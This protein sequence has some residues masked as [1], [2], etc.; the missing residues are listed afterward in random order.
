[1]D[2][3]LDFKDAPDF[4]QYDAVIPVSA[5]GGRAR[6]TLTATGVYPY[7]DTSPPSFTSVPTDLAVEATSAAGAIAT[8]DA[9]AS[10]SR[11][12]ARPVVFDPPSGSAFPFGPSAVHYSAADTSGNTASGSFTVTIADTTPPTLVPPPAVHATTGPGA[13][14]CSAVVAAWT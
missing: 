9:V 10:D 8:Y 13:T 4:A 1:V 3:H 12:G 11:D 14:T 5:N 6:T 2:V 7:P